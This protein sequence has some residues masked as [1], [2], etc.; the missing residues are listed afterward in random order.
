M[1]IIYVIFN[2]TSADPS[3][4][5]WSFNNLNTTDVDPTAISTVK[6]DLKDDSDVVTG[7]GLDV[8]KVFDGVSG[9]SVTATSGA[10]GWPEDVFDHQWFFGV[11]GAT[12]QLTGLTNGDGYSIE[13]AGHAP[14][15]ARD[16]DFTV[17]V[18]TLVQYDNAGT[19]VPNAPITI[20][21]TVS[22]TTLDI[23]MDRVSVFGYINGFKLTITPAAT[24]PVI[25]GPATI[26]ESTD[27]NITGTDLDTLASTGDV[28]LIATTGT[29]RKTQVYDTVT[30]TSVADVEWDTGQDELRDSAGFTAISGVPLD[31]DVTAAGITAYQVQI[32]VDDGT[33]PADTF[34]TTVSAETGLQV[35]QAMAAVAETDSGA[36]LF[37]SNLVV[38]ED[39]HQCVIPTAVS[40]VTLT[41]DASGNGVITVLESELDAAGGSVSFSGLYLS[42]ST[43]KWS[44]IAFT[45]T[46]EGLNVVG[47]TRPITRD[48]TRSITRSIAP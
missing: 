6:A 2:R 32:E 20:A 12:L 19:G 33:N 37:G 21:G 46:K 39:D 30:A 16:T 40:G 48:I 23:D 8:T 29:F 38:V 14:D 17:G 25:T 11:A 34:N 1:T 27:S 28:A 18:E 10:G 45:W 22:G 42:P 3:T 15:S 5:P 7:I 24:G 41:L 35:V 9:S 4:S 26:T 43:E 13:L 36:S 47:I 44:K 31:T